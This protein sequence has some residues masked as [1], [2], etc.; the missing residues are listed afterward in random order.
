MEY[1]WLSTAFFQS[2]SICVRDSAAGS[3]D[4]GS[5][6]GRGSKG[7]GGG[8]VASDL[9]RLSRGDFRFECGDSTLGGG[10]LSL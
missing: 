8:G 4:S 6:A 5:S 10:V 2:V 9:T 1:H 3:V 7:G